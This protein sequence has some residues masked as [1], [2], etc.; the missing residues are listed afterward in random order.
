MGSEVIWKLAQPG[1]E[2]HERDGAENSE[3]PTK[4]PTVLPNLSQHTHRSPS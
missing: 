4:A 1:S 3:K 2:R